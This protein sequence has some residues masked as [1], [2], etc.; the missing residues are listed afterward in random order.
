VV[1]AADVRRLDRILG[2]VLD[3]AT[4]HAPAARVQVAVRLEHDAAVV[5]VA[6]AGPGV[7]PDALVHLFDR[8]YKADASRTGGSSGLGLAIAAEHAA[9]LGGELSAANRPE[10]GLEV[11]LRLPLAGAVTES[12]PAGD[13]RDMRTR[14]APPGSD[15]IPAPTE[16]ARPKA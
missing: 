2:N 8:F 12:L 14:D 9:L 4:E 1:V 5:S 13:E 6:D 15:A 3:N 7:A 10:G 16:P 11:L